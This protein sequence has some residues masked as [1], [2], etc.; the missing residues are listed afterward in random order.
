MKRHCASRQTTRARHHPTAR[1]EVQP[2]RACR[3]RTE[4]TTRPSRQCGAACA[5][6]DTA[7]AGGHGPRLRLSD[8]RRKSVCRRSISGWESSDGAGSARPAEAAGDHASEMGTDRASLPAASL[9]R[10]PPAQ[11]HAPRAVKR[12]FF[13]WGGA[14]PI[15]EYG[16]TPHLLVPGLHWSGNIGSLIEHFAAGPRPMRLG[17]QDYVGGDAPRGGP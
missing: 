5:R 10:P 1:H 3:V 6:L 12:G 9:R 14:G 8:R 11:R 17:C 4:E 15:A 13:G 7:A 2:L 16:Q